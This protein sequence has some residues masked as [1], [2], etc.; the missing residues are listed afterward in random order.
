MSL[1]L[2]LDEDAQ[3]DR[4]L[5][6]LQTEGHDVASVNTL[7]LR[8]RTDPVI[9][10]SAQTETRIL[11]TYNAADFRVFHAESPSHCGIIIICRDADP[12]KDMSIPDISRALHNLEASGWNLDGELVFL[13]EWQY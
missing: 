13:N 7:G 2:L 12:A 1:R 11:I 8:T 4:L 10:K 9:L 5:R 6:A 3:S